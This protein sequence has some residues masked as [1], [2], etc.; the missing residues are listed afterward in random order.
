MC[1][2]WHELRLIMMHVNDESDLVRILV[3]REWPT[4][5]EEQKM[6]DSRF[7]TWSSCYA[8][9]WQM[10]S[11]ARKRTRQHVVLDLE[12]QEIFTPAF[13]PHST[14]TWEGKFWIKCDFGFNSFDMLMKTKEIWCN[15]HCCGFYTDTLPYTVFISASFL[16]AFSSFFK[17]RVFFVQ[18]YAHWG[19][20]TV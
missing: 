7:I 15:N 17:L 16:I 20:C 11:I 14:F 18:V 1:I 10:L 19:V 13:D 4:S 8:A 5:V 3:W 9:A 2:E 6:K 12:L